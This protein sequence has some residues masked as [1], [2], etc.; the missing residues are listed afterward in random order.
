VGGS[1]IDEVGKPV[2]RKKLISLLTKG[3]FNDN[4]V[5][6]TTYSQFLIIPP[7]ST[8]PRVGWSVGWGSAGNAQMHMHAHSAQNAHVNSRIGQK[9]TY[10]KNGLQLTSSS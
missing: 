5:I 1:L 7:F 8:L 10:F 4:R 3:K 6:G 9:C 2:L